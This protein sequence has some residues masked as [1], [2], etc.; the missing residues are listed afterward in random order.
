MSNQ[1][2]FVAIKPGFAE[3][4]A[5]KNEI[6]STLTSKGCKILKQAYAHYTLEQAMEHYSVIPERFQVP[7]ATYLSASPLLALILEDNRPE[8]EREMDFIAYVRSL[9]GDTRCTTPNTIRHTI[10]TDARFADRVASIRAKYMNKEIG[11]DEISTNVVHASDSE[12][13]FAR[14][15]AI[16]ERA[17]KN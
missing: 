9:Q 12:E 8:N 10:T 5:I 14:E 3:D 15:T 6:I 7:A 2:T 16:L 13:S 17:F 11:I 4:D 1:K